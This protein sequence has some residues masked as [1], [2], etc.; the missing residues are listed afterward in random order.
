LFTLRNVR[1]VVEKRTEKIHYFLH[2]TDY[3]FDV[4]GINHKSGNISL[5]TR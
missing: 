2:K 1:S 4:N 3:H 5:Q